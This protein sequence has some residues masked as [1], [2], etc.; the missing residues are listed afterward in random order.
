MWELD[1][2]CC[3]AR[4]APLNAAASELVLAAGGRVLSAD[5]LPRLWLGDYMGANPSTHGQRTV[6]ATLRDL[7]PQIRY[8]ASNN[9]SIVDCLHH[10]IAGA[11]RMW[12]Y[13]IAHY[14]LNSTRP[15]TLW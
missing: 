11:P 4:L 10:C 8:D 7:D 14:V 12:A 5:L 13:I 15:N 2:P 1:D 3:W 9:S 6:G